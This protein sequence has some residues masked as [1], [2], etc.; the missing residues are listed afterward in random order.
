MNSENTCLNCGSQC[1]KSRPVATMRRGSDQDYA[2]SEACENNCNLVHSGSMDR[3]AMRKAQHECPNCSEILTFFGGG[4]GMY[5]AECGCGVYSPMVACVA[6]M[7]VA[8]TDV[9][10]WLVADPSL[11]I[12]PPIGG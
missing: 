11:N 4:P 6:D 8:V 5:W 9:A 7:A 12:Y 3:K 2:C 1:D 10:K